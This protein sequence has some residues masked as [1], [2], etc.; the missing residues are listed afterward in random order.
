MKESSRK[1]KGEKARKKNKNP[2]TNIPEK[3]KSRG[4]IKQLEKTP[5]VTDKTPT[6]SPF[7]AL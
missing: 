3:K 7:T 6:M 1:E 2:K 4:E 5:K